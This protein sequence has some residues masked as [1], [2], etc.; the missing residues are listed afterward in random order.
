MSQKSMANEALDLAKC[1]AQKVEGRGTGVSDL[2]DSLAA[3]MAHYLRLAITGVRS[4]A[5]AYK[6]ALHFE[7][8]LS[9][10]YD[11]YGHDRVSTCPKRNIVN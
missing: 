4:E 1:T 11:R 8:F 2:P 7:Q 9:F 5:V 3:W 10:F 6:I